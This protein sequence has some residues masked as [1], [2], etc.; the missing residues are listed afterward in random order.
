[1]L[2][3][4]ASELFFPVVAQELT[5]LALRYVVGQAFQP[6]TPS[7]DGGRAPYAQPKLGTV[8]TTD[9]VSDIPGRARLRVTGLRGDRIR[10]AEVADG[11]RALDGVVTAEANSVTGTILVHYDPDRVSLFQIRSNISALH[12]PTSR[13]R[14]VKLHRASLLAESPCRLCSGAERPAS[15][16]CFQ[17][18]RVAGRGLVRAAGA[19]DALTFCQVSSKR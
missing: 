5:A 17:H 11:L 8:L 13:K 1:M 18:R 15:V 2:A 10:A 19:A 7:V 14:P 9:V 12:L 3:E 4:L 6:G 16:G